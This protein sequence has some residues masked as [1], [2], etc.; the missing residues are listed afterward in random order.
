MKALVVHNPW[1]WCIRRAAVDP[2]AKTI[3]NRGWDTSHRGTVAIIAGRRVDK[4]ALSHPLV[5]ATADRWAAEAT[6]AELGS[7]WPWTV[8]PGVVVAVVDLYGVCGRTG[9]RCGPW[10]V[11]GQYHWR[12]QRIRPLR[13][14]VP[15]VGMQR[16]FNLQ[17]D[18]AVAAVRAQLQEA[19]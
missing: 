6:P 15:A 10:A 13:R 1:A 2:A 12:L 19:A 16:L 8:A 5:T 17:P 9:C 18:A 4:P 7:P 11:T 3:E 14:P